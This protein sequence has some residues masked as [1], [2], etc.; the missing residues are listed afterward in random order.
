[1]KHITKSGHFD[2]E[3][4]GGSFQPVKKQVWKTYATG[5]DCTDD[6]FCDIF[7]TLFVEGAWASFS[8]TPNKNKVFSNEFGP[9]ACFGTCTTSEPVSKEELAP[10]LLGYYVE[11]PN[12]Q[13]NYHPAF[14]TI[15]D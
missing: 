10:A 14:I 2:E 1:M 8:Y 5:I 9:R 6:I 13:T 11:A 12:N 15:I 7:G 3:S 4:S